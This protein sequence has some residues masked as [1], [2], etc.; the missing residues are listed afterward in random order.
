MVNIYMI[1]NIYRIGDGKEMTAALLN[2]YIT[3]HKQGAVPRYQKLWDAYDG[4]FDIYNK[5]ADPDN[6]NA[7]NHQ[8]A[9]PFPRTLTE[10]FEGFFYGIPPEVS[11]EDEAVRDYIY[12]LEAYNSLRAKTAE[13]STVVSIF[14]RGYEYYYTDEEGEIAVSNL[15]PLEAFIIY[16]EGL[17][18]RPAY[19]VYFYTDTENVEHAICASTTTLRHYVNDSTPRWE[20]EEET[21]G[22]AYVPATEYRQ[23]LGS[24]GLYEDVLPMI[25][26]IAEALSYQMD[27]IAY[28]ANAILAIIGPEAD[29]AMTEHTRTKRILNI[30]A[31]D[32]SKTKAEFLGKPS[33]E[34][35]QE[36]FLDRAEELVYKL[37][38]VADISDQTFGTSSGIALQYKLLPMSNLAKTKERNFIAGF[39]HRYKVIFSHPTAGVPEDAWRG[40]SYK[41]TLNYPVDIEGEANAVNT[42]AGLVSKRTRLA[43]LSFIADEDAELEQIA[44]EEDSTLYETD[45]PTNRTAENAEES[46]AE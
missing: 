35:S 7:P 21:H 24:R 37:A 38:M 45:Y 39:D 17:E 10:N 6:P 19:F 33:A 29:E 8:I 20:G 18:P 4:Q 25:N 42:L 32:A 40:L 43:M 41:F 36:N 13:L 11:T 27:D 46:A 30:I 15:T 12:A 22:F 31:Q 26:S 5:T 34:T 3:K 44:R 16:D 14:G 2:E 23:D 28:F 9:A 1:Y